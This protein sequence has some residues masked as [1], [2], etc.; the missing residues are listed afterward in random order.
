[1]CDR[2]LPSAGGSVNPHNKSVEIFLPINPLHDLGEN[3]QACV[4]MTFGGIEP[5]L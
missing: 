2:R 1:L 5:F 3:G 4:R